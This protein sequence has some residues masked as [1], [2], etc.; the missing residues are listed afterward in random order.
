L[1]LAAVATGAVA[2]PLKE[3]APLV[4]TA[5]QPAP[6]G[7]L[8]EL[9]AVPE[10]VA[11]GVDDDFVVG[12]AREEEAA[13]GDGVGVEVE[14]HAAR[15]IGNAARRATKAVVRRAFMTESCFP[16]RGWSV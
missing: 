4:G 12:A 11:E 6:K 5:A 7:L 14:P 10:D 8:V 3:P 1:L 16:R 13:P 2:M 9:L 15:P